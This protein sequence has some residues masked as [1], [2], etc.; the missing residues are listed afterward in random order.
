MPAI[1]LDTPVVRP[2]EAEK[3]FDEIWLGSFTCESMDPGRCRI[4]AVLI[5]ARTLPDGSKELN[6]DAQTNVVIPN[7]WDV[8]TEEEL[9]VM[10]QLV[11]AIKQRANL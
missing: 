11:A 5:P 7:L 1:P 8:A 6:Y 2:P 10:Y 3:T 9:A 4:Q